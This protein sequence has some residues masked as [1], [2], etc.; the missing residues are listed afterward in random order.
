MEDN[1]VL[2]LTDM[3]TEHFET[4]KK[5]VEDWQATGYSGKF[6]FVTEEEAQEY[7]E[8]LKKAIQKTY[9]KGV[10]RG[11]FALAA[12]FLFGDLI[13]KTIGHLT[14]NNK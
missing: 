2:N 10:V 12:G 7:F 5:A 11:G 14:G 9:N 13:C 6:G 4:I 3:D 1:K 8:I